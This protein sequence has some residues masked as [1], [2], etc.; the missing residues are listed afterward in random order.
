METSGSGRGR[1][2]VSPHSARIPPARWRG[3]G[4]PRRAVPAIIRGAAWHVPMT[5]AVLNWK[6]KASAAAAL[7]TRPLPDSF[8]SA[9]RMDIRL[10]PRGKN[11][12]S[13]GPRPLRERS[14]SAR[15]VRC[16]QREFLGPQE[17]RGRRSLGLLFPPLGARKDIAAV[18]EWRYL[19]PSSHPPLPLRTGFPTLALLQRGGGER[20]LPCWGAAPQHG[21]ALRTYRVGCF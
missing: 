18:A 1:Q 16:S 13:R 5:S 6:G 2:R 4:P 9:L 19:A 7:Y 11:A 20:G 15:P 8:R 3:P 17:P 10:S 14:P 21:C 12:N